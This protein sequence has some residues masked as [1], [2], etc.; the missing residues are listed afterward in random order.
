MGQL[1]V[2]LYPVV[3]VISIVAYFPQLKSLIFAKTKPNSIS[4]PSWIMW[5]VS[6]FLAFGY[7]Y[8]HIHDALLSFTTGLNMLLVF[9]TTAL[10]VYNKYVRFETVATLIMPQT[11][12]VP[13]KIK[14]RQD[15]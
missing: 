1:F 10:I 2:F 13:V 12:P 7:A 8:C 11:Q 9:L 15:R 5:C 3:T 6:S 4:L 14:A